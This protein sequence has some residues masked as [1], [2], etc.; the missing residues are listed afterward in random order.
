MGDQLDDQGQGLCRQA[1][2]NSPQQGVHI[3]S[4]SVHQMQCCYLCNSNGF[5]HIA[6]S[7]ACKVST[8]YLGRLLCARIH[9]LQHTY[10]HISKVGRNDLVTHHSM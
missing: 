7:V 6:G 5:R 10:V 8:S 1:I 3:A 2:C 9:A 4:A